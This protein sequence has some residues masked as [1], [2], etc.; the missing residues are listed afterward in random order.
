M[1]REKKDGVFLNCYVNRELYDQ[2]AAVSVMTGNSKTAVLETA[3]KQYLTNAQKD[4]VV[5]RNRQTA[6]EFERTFGKTMRLVDAPS[7]DGI[8]LGRHDGDKMLVDVPLSDE[9][10]KH[11]LAIAPSGF[12]KTQSFAVPYIYQGIQRGESFIVSDPEG[13]LYESAK[14]LFA[15]NGYD[16]KVVDFA[17]IADGDKNGW[18][19]V[20]WIASHEDPEAAAQMFADVVVNNTKKGDAFHEYGGAL[21]LKALLLRVALGDDI[22]EDEKTL[23]WIRSILSNPNAKDYAAALFD[24]VTIPQTAKMAL[25]PWMTFS[26]IPDSA[27]KNI[28]T[29]IIT[30]LACY[31]NDIIGKLSVGNIDLQAPLLGKCAYFCTYDKC[32]PGTLP[33]ALFVA[34][35]MASISQAQ[36]TK[37]DFARFVPVNLIMEDLPSLGVVPSLPKFMQSKRNSFVRVLLTTVSKDELGDVYQD[38]A[39]NIAQGCGTWYIEGED[40]ATCAAVEEMYPKFMNANE[41]FALGQDYAILIQTGKPPV[42]V[43]KINENDVRGQGGEEDL[44]P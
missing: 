11:I 31:D 28:A 38:A 7:S 4:M 22:P 1:S 26:L 23:A 30:K 43:R 14:D 32:S 6:R 25:T 20:K 40:M 12:G 33:A 18:D 24:Q 19:C 44:H 41:I 9:A 8:V 37:K 3:L 2:L 13:R 34:S 39:K 5:L 21:L 36:K 27:K 10:A 29:G 15:N 42:I 17:N 35:A 16:V